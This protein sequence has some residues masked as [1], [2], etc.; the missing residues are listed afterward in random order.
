MDRDVLCRSLCRYRRQNLEGSGDLD[1]GD[2]SRSATEV[3]SVAH[4]LTMEVAATSL[5][6]GL[7]SLILKE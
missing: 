1:G 4:C 2:S 6:L 5:V 7:P 3:A